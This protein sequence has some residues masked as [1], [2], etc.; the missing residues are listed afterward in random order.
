MPKYILVESYSYDLSSDVYEDYQPIRNCQFYDNLEK[1]NVE[2]NYL[3][4]RF[5]TMYDDNKYQFNYKDGT[6]YSEKYNQTVYPP[7]VYKIEE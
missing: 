7:K 2:L 3:Q 4:N 5:R 1:A 6:Y